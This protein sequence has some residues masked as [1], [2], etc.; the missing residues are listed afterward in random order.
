V[1]LKDVADIG[2]IYAAYPSPEPFASDGIQIY[3]D[4]PNPTNLTPFYRWEYEYTYEIQTP[5]VS[6][7]EWIG[8]N[9]VNIRE[10]PVDRCW[11]SDTSRITLIKDNSH[12]AQTG[13]KA[14]PIKFIPADGRDLAVKCSILV[15][16]FPLDE[17][18][19]RY[20]SQIKK[21]NE[22]QGTL[23]DVQ[24]GTVR[25]NLRSTTDPTE[26]VLGY[27]DAGVV[28]AK[29][30]FFVPRNFYNA[31]FLPT[32]YFG[33]CESINPAFVPLDKIGAF[34]ATNSNTTAIV[35][36]RSDDTGVYYECW[37]KTCTDCTREGSNIMPDFWR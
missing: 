27:F 1:V 20:W 6:R 36:V 30:V 11:H 18:M 23:F 17:T 26:T 8:G 24:P 29:R 7:L 37:P 28:K 5:L 13:V 33:V 35:T 10:V 16:Q 22:T 32:N 25:G 4:S 34:M 15:K 12:L 21:I 31:G 2:S 19:F 9:N 3:L 14:F